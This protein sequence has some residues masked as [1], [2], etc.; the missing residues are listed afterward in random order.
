MSRRVETDPEYMANV[1]LK[2]HTSERDSEICSAL[3][4]ILYAIG[5]NDGTRTKN[6][7]FRRG[8]VI[9]FGNGPMARDFI[10]VIEWLLSKRTQRVIDFELIG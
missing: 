7:E 4:G 3:R 2:V 5:N 1:R 8:V 6:D 9:G 10:V